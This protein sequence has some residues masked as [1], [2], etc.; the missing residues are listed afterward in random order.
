MKKGLTLKLQLIVMLLV[1]YCQGFAQQTIENNR[2]CMDPIAGRGAYIGS[3][4]GGGICL[5]CGTANA[6]NIIDG[7]QSNFAVATLPVS[8]VNNTP[9]IIIKDSLQYYPAGNEAGFIIGADGGLL[10]ANILSN[11]KVETYRNG[12]LQET[13][14]FSGGGTL[15][16]LSVL[17]GTSGG[18]QI[19]SFVTTLDF[20]E[21]RLVSTGT[22][23]ALT[24]IRIYGAFEGPTNCAKDCVLSLTGSRTTGNPTTGTGGVCVG[25][26]VTNANN[27]TGDTTLAATITVPLLGVNCS[28][29]LQVEASTIYPAGTFAGF[30][31]SDDAGILG[32]NLL[33][34]I[35]IETYN[36]STFQESVSGNSLLS[37]VAVGGAS[38]I[39]QVGF[40]STKPFNRIRIVVQGLVSV[41]LGAAYDVYYAF[42][43]LDG[44][45][46][47]VPDC[48]DKCSGNDLLDADGDGVP[49]A[50]DNNLIDISLTK[51][52]DNATPT[53]GANVTFLVTATR[54]NTTLNATGLKVKDL[55]PVGFTYVAHSAATGTNY[56]PTTG[57][58]NVGSALGGL[59]NVLSLQ[60]TAKADSTG[61]LS[62]IAEI[63]SANETD[64]DSPYNN[65]LT[66]E[67][68]IASACVS[69]PIQICQGQMLT[70]TAPGT[71]P[72]YQWYKNNI[73][74]LGAT[75]ATLTVTETGSYSVNFTSTSGC[76][77]GNCCPVIVNVNPL[78]TI[79]AGADV[80]ICGASST[81]LTAT[82]TGALLWSTGATTASITVNPTFTTQ[83]IV[84]ATSA[85]GCVNRDTVTVTIK[86]APMSANAITIC[87]NAGT[88]STSADDTF[89][90]VLNPSGGSGTTYTV[91]VNNV[92]TG[93][94]YNYNV[95]SS[96]ILAGLIN[97][98][99]K[100]IRILDANGCELTTTVSPPANC[101]VCPPK[102]CVPIMIVKQ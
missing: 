35:T 68:D 101:S 75:N 63:I 97:S 49:D 99:S 90:I 24:S 52:V 91:F 7:D 88:P 71:A 95:P 60:L 59:T 61:V 100:S 57:I 93:V 16:S 29:Y 80:A 102:I 12:V 73:L 43:K 45:G 70:L 11:L 46:D 8:L 47:G 22:V 69:V 77:S 81:T 41:G 21:V 14:L 19:L 26:G 82:G 13:G 65:G 83:Y 51:A 33:G 85:A 9:I 27:V 76:I 74:I 28:R 96:P 58:W 72:S 78:P 40:K 17:Q 6:S 3:V 31:V 39:Y 79:N 84:S 30:A 37:A 32:L 64:T 98:G 1:S 18:K 36:G 2:I 92:S 55:L 89:T 54:D 44:D 42:V 56:N 34:G 94:T 67:D 50:C 53:Q 4:S 87:N 86:P 15:L 38:P 23:G 48:M 20:D 5:L 25:G 62:N 10:N 66:T